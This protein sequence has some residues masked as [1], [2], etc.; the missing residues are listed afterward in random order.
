MTAGPHMIES[1]RILHDGNPRTVACSVDF[2][3]RDLMTT[4]RHVPP[5]VP[6]VVARGIYAIAHG[7]VRSHL[8]AA[9]LVVTE[10]PRARAPPRVMTRICGPGV[11]R[12]VSLTSSG[13][14][15]ATIGPAYHASPSRKLPKEEPSGNSALYLPSHLLGNA[16]GQVVCLYGARPMIAIIAMMGAL[17]TGLF[18]GCVLRASFAVAVMS[19]SQERVWTKILRQQAEEQ[20]RAQQADA[21]GTWSQPAARQW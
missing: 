16:S 15:G 2:S 9:R 12:A 18:L 21:R 10:A 11:V 19:R 14:M 1:L 20:Q 6:L 7:A 3:K 4:S 5:D 13:Q 17:V 8:V